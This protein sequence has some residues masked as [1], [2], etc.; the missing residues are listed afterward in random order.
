MQ[1][2]LLEFVF[3][4]RQLLD[5]NNPQ[6]QSLFFMPPLRLENR[7]NKKW[8]SPKAPTQNQ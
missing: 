6:V 5:L 8:R 2:A 4:Q 3:N 7:V 1:F